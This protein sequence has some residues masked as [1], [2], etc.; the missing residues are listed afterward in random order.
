MHN[1]DNKLTV[2]RIKDLLKSKNISVKTMLSELNLGINYLSEAS[3]GKVMSCI[4]VAR[5]ADY[6]DCSMDYLMGRDL[7]YAN[8]YKITLE[9]ESDA[10]GNI[11]IKKI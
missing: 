3:K 5:I 10:Q 8:S 7:E 2:N 6:L 1:Y 4:N 9:I 11:K